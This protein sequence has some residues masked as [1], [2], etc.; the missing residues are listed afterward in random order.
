MVPLP[1]LQEP[2]HEQAHQPA[3][4]VCSAI[5]EQSEIQGQQKQLRAVPVFVLQIPLPQYRTHDSGRHNPLPDT[6]QDTAELSVPTP[7]P[8]H[9][10]SPYA[11]EEP[12]EPVGGSADPL[13]RA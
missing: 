13:P 9:Y 8:E 1:K 7:A 2:Q 12:Q 4:P 3:V 10:A 6:K 5:P 11:A